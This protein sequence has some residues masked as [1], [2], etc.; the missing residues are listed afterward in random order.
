MLYYI[1]SFIYLFNIVVLIYS[2]GLRNVPWVQILR[3]WYDQGELSAANVLV[4][5]LQ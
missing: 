5:R 4:H 3:H 2:K 1:Y